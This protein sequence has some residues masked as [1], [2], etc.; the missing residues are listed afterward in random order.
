ME[1]SYND[2]NNY[3]TNLETPKEEEKINSNMLLRD[4]ELKKNTINTNIPNISMNTQN[5][6]FTKDNKIKG[7]K[8]DSEKMGMREPLPT[9]RVL[10]I[11]GNTMIYDRF[12][13]SSRDI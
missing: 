8:I 2:L 4:I 6:K 11:N 7:N 12:S 9:A 10:P 1:M 3:L 5:N 13:V